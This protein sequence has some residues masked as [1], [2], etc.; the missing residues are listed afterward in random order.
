SASNQRATVAVTATGLTLVRVAAGVTTTDTSVT[1]AG[2]VTLSAVATAV[3]A[4]G[5]GW[6][7]SVIDSANNN[8]ASADLRAVQGALN[9]RGVNAELTLHLQELSAYE[10]DANHGWL[11]RAAGCWHG[12]VNFWRVIYT[13]GYA[14]VPEDVQ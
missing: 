13:A 2:N 6:S 4:L 11:V 3:N 9:A 10:V 7:A 5:N 14:T 8:R 12:G 1:F